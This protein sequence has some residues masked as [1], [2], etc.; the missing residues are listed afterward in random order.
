MAFERCR[1]NLP[2]WLACLLAAAVTAW[3]AAARAQGAP[4]EIY[5]CIDA[6]GNRLTSDRPIPACFDRDQRVLNRDGS[7]QRVVP[8]QLTVDERAAK[9]AQERKAAAD[10]NAQR[11]AVRA[12]R[13]LLLRYPDEP[14]HQRARL[15]ALDNL[16]MA[17]AESR[18][19]L[20]DLEAERKPLLD[21]AEFYKGKQ[22]P[23]KLKQQFDANDAAQDAQRSLVVHTENEIVRVNSLYDL[24]LARLRR[25]WAGADPGSMGTMPKT[26]QR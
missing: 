4:G 20:N 5:T 12:D 15:A 13:N 17:L 7:L 25:L 23:P 11:E 14:T 24:E 6:N 21:E 19:R 10:R 16:N 8:R 26:T 3:P 22:L 9:E 2:P 1:P 18:K